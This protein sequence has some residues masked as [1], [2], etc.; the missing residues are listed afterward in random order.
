M[1]FIL[2]TLVIDQAADWHIFSVK[3]KLVAS[4]DIPHNRFTIDV[5][6]I[7][8]GSYHLSISNEE[9]RLIKKFV[10]VN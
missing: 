7:Q 8:A 6:G 4:G 9:S 1:D 5:T 10:V 3:G 2:I